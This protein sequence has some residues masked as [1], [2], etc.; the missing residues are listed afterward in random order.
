MWP[1]PVASQ[2]FLCS[3]LARL[4]QRVQSVFVLSVHR[5]IESC[6][7]QQSWRLKLKVFDTPD[8]SVSVSPTSATVTA[9]ASSNFTINTSPTNGFN[10]A[11]SLSCSGLPTGAQGMFSTQSYT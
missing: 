6:A 8:F 1:K 5:H 9:G 4:R 2:A 3:C 11:V 7:D 10:S